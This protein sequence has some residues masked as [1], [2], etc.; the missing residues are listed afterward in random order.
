MNQQG[1]GGHASRFTDERNEYGQGRGWD[2]PGYPGPGGQRDFDG[3]GER[4]QQGR[5][6]DDRQAFSG[7]GGG[8]QG[9]GY[10]GYQGNQGRGEYRGYQGYQGQGGGGYARAGEQAGQGWRQG[11]QDNPQRSQTPYSSG[12]QYDDRGMN[13]YAQQRPWQGGGQRGWNEY[14]ADRMYTG[15]SA[16]MT[17]QYGGGFGGGAGYG[18]TSYGQRSGST[19]AGSMRGEGE[20]GSGGRSRGQHSGRGPKGYKRSDDRIRDEVNDQL[21]DSG[22]IDP[23]DVEVSVDDGVVT[24]TGT[25]EDR[26]DKYEMEQLAS[27]VLGV[28]DVVCQIRVKRRDQS[29][30]RSGEQI[31]SKSSTS[32]DSSTRRGMATTSR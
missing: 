22:D 20:G 24:L 25:V 1:Y 5:D 21:M 13:Q 7:R 4:S 19:R 29:S 27:S 23:S 18:E 31:E 10:G 28:Q 26:R 17:Q 15:E 2:E 9:G 6:Y 11:W 16:G 30:S 14:G 8:H 12:G 3:F 32:N